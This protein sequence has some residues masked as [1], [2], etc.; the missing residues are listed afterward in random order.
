[1]KNNK[2]KLSL[3]TICL[4]LTVVMAIGGTVAYLFTQTNSVVN[5]FTPVTPDIT[6]DEE[7]DG[8][9]KN[10]VTIKNT[11]KVDSFIRAKVV[12]TW[13]DAE[14]NV[15]PK[16]P[17]VGTDY[18]ITWNVKDNVAAD[19]WVKGSDGF[20]YYTTY[21]PEGGNTGILFTD[22][23]PLQACADKNY[24]LHI[25]VIAQSIQSTPDNAVNQTWTL[26]N[27]ENGVLTSVA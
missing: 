25:E 15:Y 14:G 22:A 17:D 2:K 12:V 21:V 11:G 6:V 3:V 8:R 20:Y 19:V 27:A 4:L 16:N 18:T 26:V 23:R 9:V 7:F 5:T 13:Q 10:N 1:M 24:T